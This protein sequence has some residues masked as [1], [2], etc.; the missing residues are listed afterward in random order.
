[1]R[2]E[3]VQARSNMT[4]SRILDAAERV[5]ED[6]G[7]FN[8]RT[9]EVAKNAGVS[10]GTVYRYYEDANAIIDALVPGFE[11]WVQDKYHDRRKEE[12]HVQVADG[13]EG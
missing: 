12:Q 6:Q 2:N 5:I 7:V 3:P 9:A 13:E 11:D 10:I 8:L 4:V 1:M